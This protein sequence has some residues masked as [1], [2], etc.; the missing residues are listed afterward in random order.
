[1]KEA[2]RW[3][4]KRHLGINDKTTNKAEIKF[5]AKIFMAVSGMALSAYISKHPEL[6]NKGI[7]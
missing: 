2:V 4:N 5:A 7:L 3:K 1:M 6:I